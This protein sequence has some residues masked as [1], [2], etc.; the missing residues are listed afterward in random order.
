MQPNELK[1][2]WALVTGASSGIGREFCIQLASLGVNLAIVARREDRLKALAVELENQ[3]ANR[4]LVLVRDL[5]RPGAAEELQY[6][7]AA[8]GIRPR[9][10]VNNAA[11]GRWGRF[12]SSDAQFYEEMVQVNA[13][14]LVALC[15]VFL[16]DL[17][18][19]PSSVV[20]NVSSPAAYQPVPYMAVYAATKAFVHSF[21]QALH[22]EWKD[23]GVLI[24]TLIPGPTQTEFDAKAGAYQSALN[25]RGSPAE[26]VRVAL[27]GLAD[28]DPLVISAKGTYK[29]RLFAGLFPARTVIK[30]VAKMF[31]PPETPTAD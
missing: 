24:K 26:V 9:L 1:N 15:R 6:T 5:A 14:A 2:S 3:Y 18:S 31:R 17:A 23:R 8:A 29:Q 10:L 11:F 22:G 7:V 13:A 25:K 12:E 21:S 28:E 16:A 4:N 27:R 30:E 19:Y 20:I